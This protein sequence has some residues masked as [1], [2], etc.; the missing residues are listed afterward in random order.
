[1]Q[2]IAFGNLCN[3]F[4]SREEL[5]VNKLSSCW[6]KFGDLFIFFNSVLIQSTQ[7]ANTLGFFYWSG[8]AWSIFL[9]IGADSFS[10]YS[11]IFAD[12]LKFR[13]QIWKNKSKIFF[14]FSFKSSN[15]Q[16]LK[17]LPKL[18]FLNRLN[19]WVAILAVYHRTFVPGYHSTSL[20]TPTKNTL[21]FCP[22]W[23]LLLWLWQ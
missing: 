23:P 17:I 4:F 12:G 13:G 2:K 10:Y 3:N 22:S 7:R 15:L 20:L 19:F 5:F 1:M 11:S 6:R 9:G 14:S 8:W 18:Y 16:I 21:Y